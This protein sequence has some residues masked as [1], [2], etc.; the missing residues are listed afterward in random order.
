[1][2]L[3]TRGAQTADFEQL[4]RAAG[5]SDAR[6]RQRYLSLRGSELADMLG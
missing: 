2:P 5:M 1:M 3:G 6:T 4:G